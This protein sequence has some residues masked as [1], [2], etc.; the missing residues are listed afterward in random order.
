[1]DREYRNSVLLRGTVMS[2]GTDIRRTT[3]RIAASIGNERFIGNWNRPNPSFYPEIVFYTQNIGEIL[4]PSQDHVEIS[5]HVNTWFDR[6]TNRMV[7]EIVGD[8][9]K[10][11]DRIL[12]YYVG[13]VAGEAD[14]YNRPNDENVVILSGPIHKIDI[15]NDGF[16]IL[17]IMLRD[18]K[19]P[20]NT[21]ICRVTC[22]ERQFVNRLKE[23]K[24]SDWAAV[25]GQV[26]AVYDEEKGLRRDICCRD[27]EIEAV[28]EETVPEPE[29]AED[30]W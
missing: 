15:R 6:R 26:R 19:N 30:V 13:S 12:S 29:Q 23:A 16:A 18:K 7:Q 11:T 24:N 9:I 20:D 27:L 28:E 17:S 1:M 21:D 8:N 10:K 25:L 4:V 2:V 22:R 14:R 3:V 5:G